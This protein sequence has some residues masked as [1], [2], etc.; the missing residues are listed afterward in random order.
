MAFNPYPSDETEI[1]LD[2]LNEALAESG[3]PAAGKVVACKTRKL[4]TNGNTGWYA[5]AQIESE[6]DSGLPESLFFKVATAYDLAITSQYENYSTEIAFYRDIVPG[7]P[8]RFLQFIYGKADES[9]DRGIVVIEAFDP[10]LTLDTFRGVTLTE[11]GLTVTTMAKLQA[12]WW[13]RSIPAS[14]MESSLSRFNLFMDWAVNSLQPTWQQHRVALRKALPPGAHDAV[15]RVLASPDSLLNPLAEFPRTI[16]QVD[17]RAENVVILED[18]GPPQAVI[19]DWQRA[20]SGPVLLD[21]AYFIG[22]SVREEDQSTAGELLERYL[23]EASSVGA[24]V[25][26][27]NVAAKMLALGSI[28]ALVIRLAVR[29]NQLGEWVDSGF[30]IEDGDWG[31]KTIVRTANLVEILG[32]RSILR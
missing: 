21:V 11:A 14:L 10:R 13:D 18:D 32:G 9:T 19:F 4:I 17:S 30:K 26:E 24:E 15:D 25:P 6:P 2:W 1:T 20:L 22:T 8:G 31:L 16:T 28:Y 7:T 12:A 27:P 5:L 3:H 29:S 23:L